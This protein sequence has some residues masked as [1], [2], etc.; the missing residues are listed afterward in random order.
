[1]ALS[2]AQTS[3]IHVAKRQLGLDDDTY[4]AILRRAAGVSS[5]RAL[6]NIGLDAVLAEL[7]RLGFTGP[8]G[9]QSFGGFRPGFISNAQ[10]H[11]IRKL[12]AGFTEG[13]GTDR[14]L[15]HWLERQFKISSLR[16]LPAYLSGKVIVAL[17]E[18]NRRR[19][20]KK[21]A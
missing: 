15:D 14:S 21:S 12:W 18:M 10:A 6:D 19:A 9:R 4:R 5:S 16:F 8:A 13:A 11:T 3:M 20:V 2:R 7:E 17:R 1:M